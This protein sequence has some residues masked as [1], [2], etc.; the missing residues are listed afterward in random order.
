MTCSDRPLGQSERKNEVLTR[1]I[2]SRL[3]FIIYVR[4][5]HSEYLEFSH[6]RH[7]FIDSYPQLKGIEGGFLW[8]A[9]REARCVGLCVPCVQRSVLG[10]SVPQ[11]LDPKTDF[12]KKAKPRLGLNQGLVI[13]TCGVFPLS[14]SF[15]DL[16]DVADN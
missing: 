14:Q 12:S 5:R 9:C 6:A 1:R 15:G 13:L 7:G 2:S 8:V 16:F 4:I 11:K 10:E 3:E